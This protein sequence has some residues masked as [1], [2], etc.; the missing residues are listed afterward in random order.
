MA[1]ATWPA[2]DV[3][4]SVDSGEILAAI[5]DF[6]P[7]A[8]EERGDGEALRIFF[9]TADLRDA[10]ATVLSAQR[11]NTTS[12]DVEDDDWPRR[13]Q[14]GLAPVTVGR[15]TILPDTPSTTTVLDPNAIT[16]VITPS[17]GFGT[18]HHATTR[19]CLKAM[20]TA[21]VR[22]RSVLDVGTGSGILAIAAM[23]LGAARA[24][25]I[26]D[27]AYA[28]EAAQANLMLNPGAR[29]V[30]FAV[31]DFRTARLLPAD[32]VVANLTGATLARSAASLLALVAR[33]GTLVLSGILSG[34]ERVVRD[35]FADADVAHSESE[36]EWLCVTFNPK[37]SSAV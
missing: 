24:V 31:A 34:E 5:D 21:G 2:L 3:H 13:S 35:A 26:D 8:A 23:Y 9:A 27:D 25:G 28:I 17:M 4:S 18:G 22:G 36:G 33:Q 15:I 32:I 1:M 37:V 14:L 29:D 12:V 7:T 16:I 30:R 19:L 20:Q 11:Y 6:S 10:A